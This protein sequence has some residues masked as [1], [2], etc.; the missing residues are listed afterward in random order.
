LRFADTENLGTAGG[1]GPLG[2]G[3]AIFH[4]NRLGTGHF[5][6][7]F[8]FDAIGFHNFSFAEAKDK[9]YAL[10]ASGKL[11]LLLLIKASKKQIFSHFYPQKAVNW[12][13]FG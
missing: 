12:R 5:F 9:D 8:A 13:F 6:F 1:A 10:R 4:G 7:G 11:S 2:G 3:F